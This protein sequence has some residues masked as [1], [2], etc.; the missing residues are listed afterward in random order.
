M[1]TQ[2]ITFIGNLL[3][4]DLYLQYLNLKG[5]EVWVI[6]VNRLVVISKYYNNSIRLP[7]SMNVE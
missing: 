7:V 4:T 5:S 3:A 6:A 2:F 1:A